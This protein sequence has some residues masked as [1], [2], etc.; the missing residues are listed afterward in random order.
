MSEAAAAGLI[1]LGLRT[2]EAAALG[3]T[4]RDCAFAIWP[5]PKTRK[6]DRKAGE[7]FIAFP[8]IWGSLARQRRN[9]FPPPSTPPLREAIHADG[10]GGLSHLIG[11]SLSCVFGGSVECPRSTRAPGRAGCL[12]YWSFGSA[13][14]EHHPGTGRYW[15]ALICGHPDPEKPHS[16]HLL[17]GADEPGELV[18]LAP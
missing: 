7:T 2:S 17:R 8:S 10:S 9:C 18:R 13:R 15:A 4:E 6:A 11:A 14:V 1:E 3:L 5:V 16:A 12:L